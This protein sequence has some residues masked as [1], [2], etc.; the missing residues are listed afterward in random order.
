MVV[1][2]KC[3]HLWTRWFVDEQMNQKYRV[4]KLCG[5]QE[6]WEESAERAKEHKK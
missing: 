4:C 3:A 1:Q 5:K 2:R 6:N